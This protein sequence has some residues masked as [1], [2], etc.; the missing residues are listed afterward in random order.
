MKKAAIAAGAGVSGLFLGVFL[1]FLFVFFNSEPGEKGEAA[2]AALSSDVQVTTDRWGVPHIFAGSDSDL[3]FAVGYVHAQER[4]WQMELLRRAGFGRL[5]EVFGSRT[6]ASDRFLRNFGFKEAA[7]KDYANLTPQLKDLLSSY[8]Q[9]VNAWMKSRRLNWPPEFV[10]L[11]FRPEPWGIL[12]CLVVKEILA[13]SLCRDFA[14]E[15]VRARLVEK[16]GLEK[17]LQVLERDAAV[18]S[19]EEIP[20]LEVSPGALSSIGASN[21]WALA[22]G[23]TESG[24][25]LLANDPHLELALPS[26]WHELDLHSPGFEVVGVSFPGFPLVVIGH[27]AWIAWG[28]TN[29]EADVE[30]VYIERLDEARDSY[31][32]RGRWKRLLKK[33]EVIRVRGRREPEKLEILWTDRGPILSSFIIK[34]N[35]PVS[36][37]WTIYE[38]GRI[39]E[40]L[41]DLNKARNWEEFRRAVALWDVP[42]QNFVYADVSGNI[43]YYL[44]GLIPLR[45]KIAAL[46]PVPGWK[47]ENA[48]QGFLEE[49]RKPV[50]LNPRKGYVITA[51]DKMVP[52]DSPFYVSCDFDPGFR[53]ARI[54]EL[55]LARQKHTV[56]SLEKIQNDVFSKRAELFLSVIKGLNPSLE[57]ARK[58]RTILTGWDG[59]MTAGREAALYAVF[60][61]V[62][63]SEV[64]AD[65]LGEVYQ[66]FSSLFSR[67]QAGLLRLISEPDSPWYDREST[68]PVETREDVFAS[69]LDQAYTWLEKRCG[70]PEKWD[71]ARLHAVTFAHTLGRSP[72]LRFFSRGPYPLPGGPF[73]IRASY[74]WNDRGDFAAAWGVSYRQVIDLS[75]WRNSVCVLSSGQSGHLLSRHYDDQIPLWL[76]GESRPM[77]FYP[78]D[79]RANAAAVF[80]LRASS[81]GTRPKA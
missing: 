23:R 49:A 29:S 65:K 80:W 52:D 48:W 24:R 36:L 19:L 27:N 50:I 14:S 75:D 11:R 37:R 38:G 18:P 78:E 63:Q 74:P 2:F 71:W 28:V 10:L 33:E 35:V 44:S 62:L 46:F 9:G 15:L 20:S 16:L 72:L 12:D 25:P 73:C 64:L 34:N 17:A 13:L 70:P 76:K 60:V 69:C 58:A 45:K 6:L 39:C 54:E 56:A 43:G 68:G 61:A 42:S 4:M 31:F 59:R 53:A 55:L 47:E 77:L 66:D 81:K 8:S 26:V 41:F 32:D 22:G 5:S 40:A 21:A 30:D 7:L 3:F 57:K 79:I 67:K 1:F 51:N